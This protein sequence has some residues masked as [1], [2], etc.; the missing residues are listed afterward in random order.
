VKNR[1]DECWSNNLKDFAFSENVIRLPN[2]SSYLPASC[3]PPG[4]VSIS[5][6][7]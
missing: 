2:H 7:R 6:Y 5:V 3:Q 4:S 1:L